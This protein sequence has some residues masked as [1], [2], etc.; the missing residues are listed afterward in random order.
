MHSYP[1]Y[2]EQ[3]YQKTHTAAIVAI[4]NG[5]LILD[6]TICY[7]EGG[8]QHGDVG[9]ISGIQLLNTTKDDA[10]TIYHHVAEHAFVVGQ[11]VSIELDW[12]HRYHYMQMHTAQHVA[13][14]L[15][16]NPFGIQTVSVHQG[17][18]ILTI[19][20]DAPAIEPALCY[21]AED[22]VNAVVRQ[23]HRVHYEVHTRNSAQNLGLRRSIKVEGDEVRLV[24]VEDVDTVAC[25]GLHVG[26]TSEIELF[27]YA[28]QEKIRGHIRLIFTVGSIAREEIRKVEA[29]V[30]ELGKLFSSPLDGLVEVAN[31]AVSSA[32]RIKSELRRA[33]QV[34]V[35]LS[36]ASLVAKAELADSVPVVYWKVPQ[37]VEMKDV[38]QA[39]VEY[40]DLALC[41]A[42]EAGGQLL[43][44]VG[45]QG[46][47]ASLIDFQAKK[48]ALL[49]AIEG[50]G[51]GKAPL[52]QGSAKAD[53]SAF[54][55][56]FRDLLQ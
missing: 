40:P 2:Y 21:Q 45:L 29:V 14:G 6:S 7:P 54:F 50:K 30:S 34:I 15:L 3:P 23:G 37:E 44:L 27:H 28:G 35:S 51:G 26:N 9:T 19:E 18:R 11:M 10:H 22:L 55:A 38:A 16:F 53:S 17:E 31:A 33:Q 12:T 4:V 32:A 46:K 56:A 43:W 8:G 36:L 20:T 48:N 24:V 25:G 42:K 1:L 49:A 47:G 39:M 41:A 5:K 52:Y 13:S